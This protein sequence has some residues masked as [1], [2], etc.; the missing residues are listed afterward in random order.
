MMLAN[1]VNGRRP[2]G[3]E[4]PRTTLIVANQ[5]LLNQWSK[6]IQLHTDGT[7]RVMRY[8]PGNRP[9]SNHAVELLGSNDIILTTYTEIMRSYPK[10]QPPESCKTQ[11]AVIAWW[12]EVHEK[13]R[14]ILHRMMFHRV[15]LDE[16]QAIK[17]HV[18]RTSVAC[19]ALMASF[20]SFFYCLALYTN[21][22]R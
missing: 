13:H 2:K 4:G 20:P 17:N 21:C 12:K 19:Q 11:E 1:I 7:L 5:N 3:E 14:G 16:A 6:E 9:D 15:V 18:G 22:S 8:G 10:F